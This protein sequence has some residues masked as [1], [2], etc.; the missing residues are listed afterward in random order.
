MSG[1][2]KFDEN[3]ANSGKP[4]LLSDLDEDPKWIYSIYK[5]REYVEYA[6]NMYKNDQE[7]NRSYLIRAKMF[8][9]YMYHSL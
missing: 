9:I 7:A 3:K 8:F 2:K 1:G 5:E 6:V 4:P